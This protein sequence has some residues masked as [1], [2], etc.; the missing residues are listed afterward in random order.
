MLIKIFIIS[1]SLT[2][3]I[4][5]VFA[6]E[7][8]NETLIMNCQDQ[9]EKFGNGEGDDVISLECQNT[10]KQL[11]KPHGYLE[12]KKFNMKFY[13][14]KNMLLIEKFI[15]KTW[16]TEIVAGK[17]TELNS[18][19]SLAIDEKNEEIIVLEDTG[20]V[21]F[22]TTKYAGNIAPFRI[23]KHPELAGADILKIDNKTDQVIISNSR[24]RR[25][26]YFSRMANSKGR[27]GKKNLEVLKNLDANLV[28][29][30]D[31]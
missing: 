16:K 1:L 10:F 3:S 9:A 22:F 26:L 18:I 23:I 5:S 8:N 20:E 29:F 19:R 30:K 25:I 6:L 13:G 27:E 24:T 28:N 4:A 7:L 31:L 21:L 15:N 17:S 11:A 14:Y 12:S 2:Y